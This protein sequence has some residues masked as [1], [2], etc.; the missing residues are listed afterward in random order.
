MEKKIKNRLLENLAKENKINDSIIFFNPVNNIQEKYLDVSIYVLPSRSEGFG[1]VLIEAMA[2]GVPCIAFDCPS[3]PKDII[4]HQ[5]DGILVEN[6]QINDFTVALIKLIEN[7]E[8]HKQMGV[9][10][11]QNV[12]RYLPE[13]VIP[14]WDVLFKK[15]ISTELKR[16]I[17]T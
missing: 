17:R 15:L 11:K 13:N 16:N 1:M 4:S 12:K 8:Q 2:C 7:E 6:G 3:G 9:L 5:N 14:L 10:A